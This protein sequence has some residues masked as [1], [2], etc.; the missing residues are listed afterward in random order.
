[1]AIP[2][3]SNCDRLSMTYDQCTSCQLE[4]LSVQGMWL[5]GGGGRVGQRIQRLSVSNE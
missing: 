5:I 1:M 4:I 2:L 3:I